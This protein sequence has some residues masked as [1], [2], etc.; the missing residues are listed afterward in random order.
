MKRLPCLIFALCATG[1]LAGEELLV[2]DLRLGAVLTPTD[3]SYTTSD[4]LASTAGSDALNDAQGL[5]LRASWS[6][7][8]AGRAWAPILAAEILAEQ[9]TYG[10][11][12]SYE[13]YVLRGL[14]GFGWKPADD[15]TLSVLALA[16]VG[17]PTF[18]VPVATGGTL[19]TAG[20]SAS[21]GVLLGLDYALSRSWGIGI[22]VGWTEEVAALSGDGVDID[23]TRSGLSAGLGLTWSWSRQPVR[24]E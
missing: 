3:F 15:W 21:T 2:R 7:S 13:Q 23:M 16:G 24:L 12:G 8:G 20:A 14:G 17:R 1:S 5:S 4:P 6:W 19:S 10:T 9:A 11:D 18:T 22:E